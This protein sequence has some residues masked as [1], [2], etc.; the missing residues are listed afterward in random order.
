MGL[1]LSRALCKM[2]H[3]CHTFAIFPTELEQSIQ[4]V[5]NRNIPAPAI[6]QSIAPLASEIMS[7]LWQL[8]TEATSD[9]K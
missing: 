9:L 6:W 1:T 7:Y 3:F 5:L 8:N 2:Q 4:M